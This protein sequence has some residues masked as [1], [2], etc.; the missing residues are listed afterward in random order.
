MVNV[1]TPVLLSVPVPM[2]VPLFSK[3]TVPVGSPVPGETAAT[4]AVKVTD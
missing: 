1:A 2:D 4:L 3:V